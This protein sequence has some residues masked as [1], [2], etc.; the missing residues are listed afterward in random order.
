LSV[1][2]MTRTRAIWLALGCLSVVFLVFSAGT[3]YEYT[4]VSET[5]T[6]LVMEVTP[7]VTLVRNSTG[8][9]DRLVLDLN[10]TVLNTGPK[11]VDFFALGFKAWLRDYEAEALPQTPRINGDGR[12]DNGDGTST[13]WCSIFLVSYNVQDTV[14]AS[15]E[16]TFEKTVN[17]TRAGNESVFR[18]VEDIAHYAARS[19]Y[20]NDSTLEWFHFANAILFVSGIPHDPAGYDSTAGAIPLIERSVNYDITPRAGGIG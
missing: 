15:G 3:A 8:A 1:R 14:P 18:T 10:V 4:Q 5:K 9:L 19:R 20:L 7:A 17:A 12:M 2:G 6:L 16:R 13:L 11:G